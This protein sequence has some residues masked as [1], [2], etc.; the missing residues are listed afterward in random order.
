MS[1]VQKNQHRHIPGKR[2]ITIQPWE[3]RE[4]GGRG[5]MGKDLGKENESIQCR[6]DAAKYAG[7]EDSAE[8]TCYGKDRLC[9]IEFLESWS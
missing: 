1:D 4:G 3:F 2:G 9:M 7:Q 6:Q 8:S 5:I